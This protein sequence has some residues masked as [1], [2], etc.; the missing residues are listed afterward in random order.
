MKVLMVSTNSDLA[1]APMHVLTLAKELAERGCD[2]EILFGGNG[3]ALKLANEMG[4]KYR[5]IDQ[6]SSKI[7]IRTDFF[8]LRELRKEFKRGFDIIHLHSTKASI[9]GRIASLALPSQ[10]VYTVHGWGY[11][12]FGPIK[13]VAYY[14]IELSFA[15]MFRRTKF[16]FVAKF[17]Q[18]GLLGAVTR[19]KCVIYNGIENTPPA[20]QNINHA[21]EDGNDVRLICIARVDRSK[22]HSL[23]LSTFEHLKSPGRLTLIGAGT[24]T[25]ILME[26][27]KVLAP[28]RY[29]EIDF[30]GERQDAAG[31][32][33]F[34]TAFVL[35]SHFEAL[36]LTIIEA[37]RAGL[38]II[39]SDVGGNSELVE[40][41]EQG[42]LVGVAADPRELAN[43]ID[44]YL[45]DT[46]SGLCR[47]ANTSD[48]SSRFTASRMAEQ[49]LQFYNA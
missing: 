25:E 2:V 37:K 48:F 4:I 15:A 19:K 28:T 7:N 11:R 32:L 1:G 16:I 33:Q 17:L 27:A 6:L 42:L 29:E 31:Y 45:L 12:G 47:L 14:L 8:A 46:Q 38:P 24:D 10:T 49:T 13:T 34:A 36:P 43:R 22:N 35:L 21:L 20:I 18:T 3:G 40:S 23:L 30:L 5:T 39:C 26:Q 44:Q 9:L 41:Q